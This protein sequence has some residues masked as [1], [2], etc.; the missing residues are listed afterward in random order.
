[1]HHQ[2]GTT[3]SKNPG[4]FGVFSD[5]SS[6]DT[7]AL[8]AVGVSL[9]TWWRSRTIEERIRAD[10]DER[11]KFDVVFGNPVAARLEA[12]ESTI[13]EVGRAIRNSS[14]MAGVAATI[15]TIQKHEHSEWYFSLQSLVDSHNESLARLL[16]SELNEY[17]DR[18]SFLI[19]EISNATSQ[20]RSVAIFRQLQSLAD[21]YLV[22]SRR[23]IVEHRTSIRGEVPAFPMISFRKKK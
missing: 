21:G 23:L 20:E 13:S 10:S 18:A 14:S 19:D 9:V 1:M 15:S 5:W 12:L 8:I 4:G 3:S 11:A 22:R 7:I 17:W 16:A 6:A 2:V